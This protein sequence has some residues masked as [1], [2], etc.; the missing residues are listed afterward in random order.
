MIPVLQQINILLTA[1]QHNFS[2][3]V[4]QMFFPEKHADL[5]SNMVSEQQEYTLVDCRFIEHM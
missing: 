5:Y 2:Y 3:I 1:D 4:R